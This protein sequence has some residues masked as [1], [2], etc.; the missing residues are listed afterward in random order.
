MPFA[1]NSRLQEVIY[2]TLPAFCVNCKMQGHNLQTCKKKI[3]NNQKEKKFAR[4]EYREVK[5]QISVPTSVD[6]MDVGQASNGNKE[7]GRA[8]KD[9]N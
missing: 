7:D 6:Q 8:E 3:S 1:S 4:L 9:D 5:K 2:G